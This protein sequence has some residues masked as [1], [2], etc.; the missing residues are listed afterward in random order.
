MYNVSSALTLN[1][2][3]GGGE[4]EKAVLI[5]FVCKSNRVAPAAPPAGI[6]LAEPSEADDDDELLE[7]KM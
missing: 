5:H 3:G 6:W 2:F 4:I 7:A 1:S